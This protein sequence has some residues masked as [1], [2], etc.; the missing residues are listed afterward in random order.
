MGLCQASFRLGQDRRMKCTIEKGCYALSKRMEFLRRLLMWLELFRSYPCI[1]EDQALQGQLI[2]VSLFCFA[3]LFRMKW[4][5]GR[6]RNKRSYTV[7]CW[8]N[9]SEVVSKRSTFDLWVV[10]SEW[11]TFKP[12]WSD[13][14][15]MEN[16][17]MLRQSQNESHSD[18][19]EVR[20]IWITLGS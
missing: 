10:L 20:P 9:H 15:S 18:H 1:V 17:T 14:Y 4:H 2:A 13:F 3:L 11:S 19:S 7:E 8:P 16:D 6:Q 12:Q 5:W